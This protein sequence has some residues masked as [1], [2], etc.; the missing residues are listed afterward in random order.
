MSANK[1]IFLTKGGQNFGPFESHEIQAMKKDGRILEYS[2]IWN[3]DEEHWES[4]AP[5]PM[6]PPKAATAKPLTVDSSS[7]REAQTKTAQERSSRRAASEI[8]IP[9]VE[10]VAF[11]HEQVIPGELSHVT[12]DGC[13][14]VTNGAAQ[15]FASQGVVSLNVLNS[16]S[17][18]TM[19]VRAKLS[20]VS[21]IGGRW[22]Y[23]LHWKE[24]PE[25]LR[26][27]S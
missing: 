5:T 19:S 2:H 7:P 6:A 24:C 17:G 22:R 26:L 9:S 13:E 12:E 20:G 21:R 3:P 16:K 14:F 11:D 18:K 10:V 4:T 15:A 27:A 8:K 23:Q 1:Q 25:I